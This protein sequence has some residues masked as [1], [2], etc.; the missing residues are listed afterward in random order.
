MTIPGR[1]DGGLAGARSLVSA[2]LQCVHKI[3]ESVAGSPGVA[4]W[5]RRAA[6]SSECSGLLCQDQ[7]PSGFDIAGTYS[8]RCCTCSRGSLVGRAWRSSW[9]GWWGWLPAP[10]PARG[11]G[12]TISRLRRWEGSSGLQAK[13]HPP[14]PPRPPWGDRKLEDNVKQCCNCPSRCCGWRSSLTTPD[15][16]WEG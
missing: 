14:A 1:T 5:A 16:G 7:M 15:Y 9:W 8:R 2:G 13:S 4:G 3:L 11:W 6:D 10:L 12:G